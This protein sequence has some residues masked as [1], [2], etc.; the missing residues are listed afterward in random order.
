MLS[1]PS[2]S[3]PGVYRQPHV[4][5][6]SFP[7]LR[8]DVVGFV[9]IAGPRFLNEAVRVDDWRSYIEYF[10]RDEQGREIIEPQGSSLG[11]TVR[12]F[13]A[14][15]GSRC[16]IVNVAESIDADNAQALLNT[17]LGL[18]DLSNYT[19]LELLLRQDEV[20][21]V[22]LPELDATADVVVEPEP[23]E[24]PGSPC[25]VRCRDDLGRTSVTDEREVVVRNALYSDDDIQ[26]AQRYLISRLQKNRWR[27]FAILST[28]PG[29]THSEAIEWRRNLVHNLGVCDVAG[30][31]WPW[32]LTQK[33]PGADV[34]HKSP[35]GFVAGI[36]ARRDLARGPHIAPANE[37]LIGV[38]GLERLISDEVNGEVYDAGVNVI[39]V[40]AG[41][42]IRLWGAR[43]MLWDNPD[44][45]YRALAFVNGRRCLTAIA[46]TAESLGRRVVFQPHSPLVQVQLGQMLAAYLLKVYESGALMGES[47][48]EA[49][50]VICDTSNNP[51]ESVANGE[52]VC[53]IGVA[54][55]APAEFIVF[56]VG[57]KNAVTEIQEAA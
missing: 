46:R 56:R 30:I 2:Y 9:G 17:M 54:L 28:P 16:W 57:R 33:K 1:Q 7:R 15:G 47:P 3:V 50:F 18:D 20:S 48:E 49:F 45:R 13:F 55:A 8:T 41:R 6:E 25:F 10:R 11:D 43:T 23:V 53:D 32:V 51:P 26:W 35:V 21:I 37:A 40:R 38:V 14:N 19:G 24:V 29:K 42:G 5:T 39:R 44:S 31:Y 22:A 52:L 12:E 34:E 4:R 36:F 27:W